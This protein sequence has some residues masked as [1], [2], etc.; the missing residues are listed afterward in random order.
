[1]NHIVEVQSDSFWLNIANKNYIY[2]YKILAFEYFNILF[3]ENPMGNANPWQTI[4][5]FQRIQI[6]R[7]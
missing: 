5:R 3:I 6:L 2:V 7:N 4:E 1:M